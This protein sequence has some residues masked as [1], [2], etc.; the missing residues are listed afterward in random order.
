MKGRKKEKRV[1]K[2][3]FRVARL[4]PEGRRRKYKATSSDFFMVF[5][6][7]VVSLGSER[8]PWRDF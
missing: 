6:D 5:R 7:Q 1:R 3:D 4:N 2:T 8:I